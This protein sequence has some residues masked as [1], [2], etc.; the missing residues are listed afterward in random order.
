MFTSDNVENVNPNT[1]S[2]IECNYNNQKST[3]S[4][5]KPISMFP[6]EVSGGK[7]SGSMRKSNSMNMKPY[8]NNSVRKHV[9]RLDAKIAENRNSDV[10]DNRKADSPV[11][12]AEE[13]GEFQDNS[14]INKIRLSYDPTLKVTSN[15]ETQSSSV[16]S[17]V[18]VMDI[19]NENMTQVETRGMHVDLPTVEDGISVDLELD[20][21][22][23]L[24]E[25]QIGASQVNVRMMCE[26][27]IIF[28]SLNKSSSKDVNF[29]NLSSSKKDMS[30]SRVDDK[31]D[32]EMQSGKT[33]S[34]HTVWTAN[35]MT[36]AD[37]IKANNEDEETK[38]L[39]TPP[40]ILSNGKLGIKLKEE[41][42]K[43]GSIAY[44]LH[45]YGY[46]IGIDVPYP[47]VSYH[48]KRMWRVHGISE[49]T[50]NEAG[51]FFFKFKSEEGMKFVLE[52]GPWLIDNVPLILN[53]WKPGECIEKSEHKT[54]PLWVSI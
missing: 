9:N 14:T 37:M 36:F 38:M 19:S 52:S 32:K 8:E 44:S 51:F 24:N 47:V 4:L 34:N 40:E 20:D 18:N 27:A 13:I 7:M 31:R 49:I 45:L 3:E 39:Y 53:K 30:S 23:E 50:K 5:K 10:K 6:D 17:K 54:V 25:N 21:C 1:K 28:G 35:R 33:A 15:D 12:V 46:F 43:K 22:N 11:V 2:N 16:K 41:V 48:L 29:E 42:I 26:D